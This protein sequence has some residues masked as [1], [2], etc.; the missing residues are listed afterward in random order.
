[1]SKNAVISQYAWFDG[2]SSMPLTMLVFFTSSV[3]YCVMLRSVLCDEASLSRLAQTR[4]VM[5]H[6]LLP[7]HTRLIVTP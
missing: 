5:L 6:N 4:V 7:D 3:I 1:M 2:D